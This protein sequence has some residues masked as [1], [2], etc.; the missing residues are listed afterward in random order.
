MTKE[1][2]KIK[3]PFK[4]GQ[5]VWTTWN[6]GSIGKVVKVYQKDD[7]WVATIV[8]DSGY[9]SDADVEHI[10]LVSSTL[11]KEFN[12]AKKEINAKLDQA[13]NLLSEA[14]V[15]ARNNQLIFDTFGS[16]LDTSLLEES[17]VE[18]GWTPDGWRSSS[19]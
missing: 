4:K 7:R 8:W 15:L 2:K 13:A 12:K 17:I 18:M 3:A 11:E 19:C 14:A 6:H 1:T 9:K 5:K 16:P 10:E